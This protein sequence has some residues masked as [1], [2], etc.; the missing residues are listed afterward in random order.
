MSL[1]CHR[2][3]RAGCYD[4]NPATMRPYDTV[5]PPWGARI[6]PCTKHVWLYPA[7]APVS[8]TFRHA[9]ETSAT[10]KRLQV[11]GRAWQGQCGRRLA[12]SCL[13]QGADLYLVRGFGAVPSAFT[14]WG[15]GTLTEAPTQMINEPPDSSRH[16][17]LAATSALRLCSAQARRQL[18][19]LRTV[20][21]SYEA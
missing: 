20:W 17:V 16:V 18:N 8:R 12:P 3:A 5:L 21:Q 19:E 2:P 14:G 13:A 4:T 15:E 6:W 10:T 11:T 7:R 9:L 1:R